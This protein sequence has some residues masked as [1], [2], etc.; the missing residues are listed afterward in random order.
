MLKTI[1]AKKCCVEVP[2]IFS[3]GAG[4]ELGTTKKTKIFVVPY[5]Y[6]QPCLHPHLLPQA[7]PLPGP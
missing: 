7:L 5:F 6:Y 2:Y 4:E 1:H 3:N